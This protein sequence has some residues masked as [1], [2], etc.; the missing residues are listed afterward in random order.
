[1]QSSMVG[2]EVR[3]LGRRLRRHSGSSLVAVGAMALG[4]GLATALFSILRGVVLRDLPLENA[5]RLMMVGHQELAFENGGMGILAPDFVNWQENQQS[6]EGLGAFQAAYTYVTGD[7]HTDTWVG[8]YT[9]MGAFEL[10]GIRPSLGRTFTSTDTER[11]AVPVALVGYRLWKQQLGG[12][13]AV[14]GRTIK[15]NR[16]L[17][18]VVGVMPEGFGFPYRHQIWMPFEVYPDQSEMQVFAFGKLLPGV[19]RRTARAELQALSD[20]LRAEALLSTDGERKPTALVDPYIHAI[21]DPSTRKSLTLL[22]LA[23]VA[24]LA[25]ACANVA[26]LL[27]ARG[28]Q[29]SAELSLRKAL[30]ARRHH[31]FFPLLVESLGLSAL[32]GGFGL[33]LAWL[34][35]EF[36]RQTLSGSFLRAY[37]IDLR[38][39]GAV[40]FFVGGSV[41]LAALV[42]G[43]VPAWRASRARAWEA[44]KGS[45]PGRMGRGLGPFGRSLVT[46]QVMVSVAL[47][48][49]VGLMVESV[50]RLGERVEGLAV[51]SVLTGRF[52]LWQ[53]NQGDGGRWHDF[54]A[55]TQE[56]LETLSGVES[57]AL[58]S[59]LPLRRPRSVRLQ[60]EGETEAIQAGEVVVSPG[61]F[62]TFDVTFLMGRDFRRSDDDRGEGVAI[63]NRSFAEHHFPREDPLNRI[64]RLDG[65]QGASVRVVGV[66]PDIVLGPLEA[67]DPA[68]VYLPL[69]QN[70][71]DFL[72]LA[73]RVR[74]EP[75]AL[76]PQVRRQ[77][78]LLDR[79]A[80]FF[81]PAT[82]GEVVRRDTWNHHTLVRLGLVMGG[83]TL[84][85]AAAGLYAV[86]S[87]SLR[88][89]IYELGIRQALGARPS[90]LLGWVLGSGLIQVGRGLALGSV[91]AIV[92]GRLLSSSLEG[93]SAWHLPSFLAVSVLLVA[94][95]VLALAAPAR[96]A[97]RV[98]PAVALRQD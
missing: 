74:E 20:G 12:D 80:S 13:P 84:L 45:G 43:A 28:V 31:L 47:L 77:I 27:L 64:L 24:V 25:V 54:H 34:G 63:V 91:F 59:S 16:T 53:A 75:R 65:G 90:D 57:V 89:R 87:F 8:A 35:L 38:L 26:N 4:I 66:V 33:G 10:L 61:Y 36:F 86:L 30:G 81:E 15:V 69:A 48:V 2:R 96:W 5:D 9:T 60:L 49:G 14:I 97:S 88:R 70:P 55:K 71:R 21:T 22:F 23:S 95:A 46:V 82:F 3:V 18:T 76:I 83:C 68:A 56:S 98:D 62:R 79:E 94:V 32:G 78:S 73:L 39:D 52:S 93:V 37:W 11:G 17:R 85:L 51:D 72:T 6:F 42:A 50:T 44:S 7:D 29:R 1:M 92:L 41:L 40:L 67:G 58:G 19:D